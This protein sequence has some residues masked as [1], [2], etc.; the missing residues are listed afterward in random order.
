MI[1]HGGNIDEAAIRFGIAKDEWL[2]LSTGLNPH[3]W[4]CDTPI[5]QSY[6]QKLP[7]PD[8]AFYSVAARYYKSSNLLAVPGSQ[9]AIQSIPR[10]LSN[11]KVAL[12]VPGYE[13]HLYHWQQNQHQCITYNPDT[14]NLVEWVKQHKPDV[15]VVI[16]P[17]NPSCCM[18]EK[19]VLVDVLNLLEKE[20]GLLIVD[21]AFLETYSDK[22]LMEIESDNLIVLRSLGKFFGLPGI[23]VGFVKAAK[24]WR[25][26]IEEYLGSWAM[27]GPSLWVTTQCL[28]DIAWQQHAHNQLK[29][30][31]M[32][33]T[34]FLQEMLPK[35]ELALTSTDYF[36]SYRTTLDSAQYIHAFYARRGILVRLIDLSEMNISYQAIIRFGLC[37]IDCA[38]SVDFSLNNDAMNRFQSTTRELNQSLSLFSES[39]NTG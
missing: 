5:P 19:Q 10:L 16:N 17:N 14:V 33:Q 27:N 9:A 31:A 13:E 38:T 7:H 36:I 15:V 23:R 30:M 25:D 34:Q 11:K 1:K 35:T 4:K 37:P 29:S 32:L 6:Y 26:K 28:A 8:A 21:E 24:T 18:H 22:S 39:S 12:P 2:D 3:P 20:N